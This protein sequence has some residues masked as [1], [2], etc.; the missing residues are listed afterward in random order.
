MKPE[1]LVQRG[2]WEVRWRRLRASECKK[3][4]RRRRGSSTRLRRRKAARDHAERS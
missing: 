3:G 4:I 2:R 1:M